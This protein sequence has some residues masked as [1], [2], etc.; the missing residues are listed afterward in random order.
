MAYLHEDIIFT[1]IEIEHVRAQSSWIDDL[2][3]LLPQLSSSS[4]P[5]DDDRLKA[6]QMA[7]TRI[8]AALAAENDAR[9]IVGVVLL[10]RTELLVG[11]KDWIEDVVVDEAYRRRGISS[12]LMDLAER[13][14]FET[15]AKSLNLTSNPDR[16]P[17]RKM[18]EDR[19][20]KLRDTGVFR[21]APPST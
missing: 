5:I 13:A 21:L 14:S 4:L 19:G 3:R 12:R 9:H 16:G 8:F 6:L 18:Y 20:Y 15:G 17:A 11:T 7:D 1:E 2:N 10:C